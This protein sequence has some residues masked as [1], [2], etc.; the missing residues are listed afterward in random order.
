MDQPTPMP[1]SRPGRLGG[2]RA[3]GARIARN[4]LALLLI[5]AALPAA[6]SLSAARASLAAASF[7]NI[8]LSAESLPRYGKLE[9]SFDLATSATR[10]YYPYAPADDGYGHPQGI[11]VDAEF[12]RPDG[13]KMLVPAFLFVPYRR[14][15]D[16]DAGEALGV[17][18]PAT[19]LVRFAPPLPGAY[20]VTLRATDAGGTSQSQALGFTATDAGRRGFLRVAAA[21]PRFLEY[22]SGEDFQPI[23]QG[24]QWAP[25]SKRVSSSYA[26]AFAQDARDGINLTRIWDQN[27]GYNLSIEGS[28]PVWL[29][30]WSQFAQAVG[31]DLET[32]HSGSRAARF[33]AT[34]DARTDAY[35][36]RVAVL[37]STAYI[38]KGFIRTSGISGEGAFL[39][40][41]ALDRGNPGTIRTTPLTGTR[42]WT[43]VEVRFTTGASQKVLMIWAGAASSTGTAWFDDLVLQPADGAAY[44]VLSDPGF[45]RH[46]V[47]GDIG[48]DPED[49]AINL[50]VPKGTEI[51]Q[52]AAFQ[53]DQVLDAAEASGVAVQLCSHADVYWTWDATIYTTNY[54]TAN[55]YVVGWNDPRHLGYWQRNYRYRIA[56]WGYSPAVLAWEVWN[57]HGHIDPGT[58][59]FEFYQR[60]GQFI[61]DTDPFDHLVTTSQGS[62]AYSPVFWSQTPMDIAN[63]HDYMTTQITTHPQALTEDEANFVYNLAQWL[64]DGWPQGAPRKPFI[65]GEIGTL[66]SWDVDDP[67]ATTGVGGRVSRHNFL[68]AGTFSP[69]LTSPIDWQSV[70]KGEHTRALR[71]FIAGEPSADAGW[72]TFAT[73][74]LGAPA[75]RQI[76]T[77]QPKLRVMAL[78]SASENRLLAWLQHKDYTWAKV[79]RDQATPAPLSGS[80]TTPPLRA[81]RYQVEWWDTYT[82][83]I[84]SASE[85][86]HPGGALTLAL[87]APLANDLALKIKA[88][89]QMT[90]FPFIFIVRGDAR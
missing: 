59:I 37:P 18:G 65:W 75:E 28:Y 12:T 84:T 90:Y 9:I 48:N 13:Q 15:D 26:E 49:P 70:E 68:W 73:A 62:Y 16:R 44:N 5:G 43:A 52:W 88:P 2:W 46:F 7:S 42:D 1:A 31:I 69:V 89:N 24:R 27:D 63:Y 17:A 34:S 79:A 30:T 64:V 66:S 45:E 22:D 81:G 8:R 21:D 67:V 57:E 23:A 20:Q 58:E 29:P 10:P 32:T 39:N 87:P 54:A 47:K 41:N 82:G 40:A 19:W 78:R 86:L 11:T 50:T 83:E 55:N 33:R 3:R 38:L 36:Q 76:A 74:D 61:R 77:S 4:L 6:G 25:D 60:F 72:Q 71:R 14:E 51:N 35:T 56:R 80:F 85:V 53:L